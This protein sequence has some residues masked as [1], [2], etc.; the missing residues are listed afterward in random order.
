M[1]TIQI[2][3]IILRAGPSVDVPGAPTSLSPLQF[4]PGLL[5]GEMAFTTDTG[6]I[7]I[8][9]DPQQGNPNFNRLTFPYRNIEVLTE[10]STDTMNR[11][12]GASRREEGDFA[13]HVAALPTH[14]SDWENVVLPRPGD[15]NYVYR[16]PF[17]EGVAATISYTA[18][19]EEVKPV[20]M[21]TL[22]VQHVP[23]EAEPMICDD[24]TVMRK[25]GLLEPEVHQAADAFLQVEFRFVVDGPIGARYLAFQYKN[26]SGSV[27]SLRFRTSK[28]KA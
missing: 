23:G 20:K 9:H 11:I 16:I 21:G 18:Y 2:S 24:A 17:A 26:R 15:D 5:P 10:N 22:T 12:L 28:P 13:Y 4:G 7:Y 6:R 14:T 1:P 8:G 27:L 25:Q 3:Q 19:T